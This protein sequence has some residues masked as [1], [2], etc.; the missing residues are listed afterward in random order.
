MILKEA[1]LITQQK[2]TVDDA[3][4]AFLFYLLRFRYFE[5]GN[6]T[7]LQ[8]KPRLCTKEPEVLTHMIYLHKIFP[9]AKFIHIY[10][11]GRA[12]AHSYM[13]HRSVNKKHGFKNFLPFFNRWN[14][15]VKQVNADCKLVGPEK[16]MMIKYEE[17]VTSPRPNLDVLMSFLDEKWTDELLKH[18]E[19]LEDVAVSDIE[20]STNQI[21][22]EIHNESISYHVWLD[23][24]PDYNAKAID[25]TMLRELNYDTTIGMIEKN[26]NY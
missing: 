15:F 8:T 3:A 22:K 16:C 21:K 9:N 4:R 6:E 24:M 5:S 7:V 10:R 19:H 26:R 12:A 1:G 18:H 23:Q 14:S 2:N 11:D 25:T 17:L 13:L 20:W